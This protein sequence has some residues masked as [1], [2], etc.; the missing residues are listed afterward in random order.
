MRRFLLLSLLCAGCGQGG[1]APSPDAAEAV[2]PAAPA[3]LNCGDRRELA[4]TFHNTGSTEWTAA[5]GYD[6]RSVDDA[7]AFVSEP[8]V[9]LGDADVIPPGGTL[10]V[11]LPIR[12]P[13][14]AGVHT[15]EW[16]VARDGSPFGAGARSRRRDLRRA[17]SRP[18][19]ADRAAVRA[20]F[21]VRA[22]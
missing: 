4:L 14:V 16:R 9:A 3:E 10:S 17:R 2:A 12:A 11:A 1:R 22:S 21:G 13:A 19:P 5:G 6:L 7:D 18:A 20:G 15:S 8:F